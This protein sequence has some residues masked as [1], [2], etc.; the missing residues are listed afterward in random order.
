VTLL[1]QFDRYSRHALLKNIGVDGQASIGRGTAVVIGL[2]GLGSTV[3]GLLARAGVGT[4]RLIDPDIVETHNLQRQTLYDED[5]AA[6]KIHKAVAAKNR[7][8][9]INSSINLQAFVERVDESNV[10][11]LIG[12]ATV[13]VDGLDNPKG[14]AVVN[15]ACVRL[16]IPWVH[17][18]CVATYGTVHTVI[19]GET[20]CYN[21]LVPD[22]S[23]K[24]QPYTA[25]TVGILGA[26]ASLIGCWQAAEA[27]KVLA[28]RKED[29]LRKVLW[30][31]VWSN[32]VA[33]YE[34]KRNPDCKVCGGLP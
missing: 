22:A 13:V 33:F 9:R 21:C 23:A 6:K 32:Q 1:D 17:A 14:R 4:L 10:D 24:K 29:V 31:D 30:L 8:S 18:A 5:D 2:G 25:G 26:L 20:A 28:G 27:L 16:G 12:G 19:P 7:L 3:A 11:R 15:G 34:A